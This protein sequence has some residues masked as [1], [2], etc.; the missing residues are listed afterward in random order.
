MALSLALS[1][2][3][4][5][6]LTRPAYCRAAKPRREVGCSHRLPLFGIGG[7]ILA[8]PIAAALLV[9]VRMVYVEDVL[10]DRQAQD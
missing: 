5:R 8:T 7:L 2:H 9:L 4:P 10:G 1:I 6:T 3:H